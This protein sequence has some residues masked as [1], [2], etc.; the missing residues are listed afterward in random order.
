MVH[1]PETQK[2]TLPY[3]I[4]LLQPSCISSQSIELKLLDSKHSLVLPFSRCNAF[5][6]CH[7]GLPSHSLTLGLI[8]L[9]IHFI[10]LYS[11]LT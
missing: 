5:F 6:C 11:E 2:I 1:L 3:L 10:H 7:H 9:Y 8:L 4:P